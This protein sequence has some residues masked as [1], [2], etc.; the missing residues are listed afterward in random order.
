MLRDVLLIFCQSINWCS[1]STKML[2][3][4]RSKISRRAGWTKL[5]PAHTRIGATFL[6]GSPPIS[7]GVDSLRGLR[8]PAGP[9]PSEQQS[10]RITDVLN[11]LGGYK[12][13]TRILLHSFSMT[14][15]FCIQ[16]RFVRT[17][18]DDPMRIKT[19]NAIGTSSFFERRMKHYVLSKS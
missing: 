17:L 18:C 14:A 13:W 6:G 4:P 3:E 1:C 11:C 9:E 16:Y 2:L 12:F 5:S 8:N 10:S 15:A 7:E 19:F